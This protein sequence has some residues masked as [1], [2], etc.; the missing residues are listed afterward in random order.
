MLHNAP[1]DQMPVM[2]A[3]T[4]SQVGLLAESVLSG[5]PAL[6]LL[7]IIARFQGEAVDE[8]AM[9][10]AWQAMASRHPALRMSMDPLNPAGP[11][12]TFHPAIEVDF[13]VLDWSHVPESRHEARL[14]EWIEQD[15][16]QAVICDC[17]PCWR[18]RLI[19]CA[20]DQA[21]IVWTFHHALLDGSGYRIILR[22]M[23]DL[24]EGCCADRS[25]PNVA[26]D[27]PDFVTF[28]DAIAALDH[29]DAKIFFRDH[30]SGFDTPNRLDPIFA[31]HRDLN[32]QDDRQKRMHLVER[33]DAELSNAIRTRAAQAGSTTAN[34]ISAA[35]A[36]V[37]ARCS[38]RDEVVFGLT[39][40]GRYLVKDGD[41]IAG[42]QINTLPCRAQL[43]GQTVDA[44][45]HQLR[46]FT[47]A[48]HAFEH[49][50]SSA[51]SEV[52]DVQGG[53]NL[54]DSFV[55]FE[56]GSLPLQMQ[57]QQADRHIEEQSQMATMMS[58]SAY[59]DPEM[60]LRFDGDPSRI[61]D[62]GAKRIFGYLRTALR[63]LAF[64]PSDL[65][66]SCVDMLSASETQHLLALSKPEVPT[67]EDGKSIIAQFEEIARR[68]PDHIA[69]SQ[70]GTADK[71]SYAA[72][73][74]YANHLAHQLYDRGV[75]PGQ[76]VGLALPRGPDF[77]AALLAVL[78]IQAVFLPLDPSYP[79]AALQD[80]I[81]R[82]EV[83]ATFATQETA[84]HFLPRDM[85]V[86]LLGGD[87][88]ISG[89]NAPLARGPYDPMGRAYIIFTSGSTGK[90][91][92]VEVPHS[93]LSQHAQAM[94]HL[95]ALSPS[96]HVL[97]F[98]SLNF[99]V[100]IEEILP[101]LLAGGHLV[102]RNDDVAQSIPH[103][104]AA[105]QTHHITV[106]NLPTAFW[107]VLVAHLESSGDR[108]ASSLRLMIV[109]GER[110]SGE[111]LTSWQ[112]M[113][114]DIR[115]VN[116]YGPTEATIT[117]VCYEATDIC[118]KG[119]PVPIGRPTGHARAYVVAQDGSLAPEGVSGELWV[120]GAAVALGYLH[121][122]DLTSEVFLTDHFEAHCT[123]ARPARIY[124]T[125][126]RVAWLPEGNLAYHGRMDRQVKLRGYRIELSAIEAA[127]ETHA[128]VSNVV[129]L[130]DKAD[131]DQARL[132]AW[133]RLHDGATATDVSL[134]QDLTRHLPAYMVPHITIVEHFPE[135]P[136]GKI[137]TAALPRPVAATL[138]ESAPADAATLQVM[139]IFCVL[140][141]RKDV[142]P[143]QSFFDLGG[144]SLLSVRL[145]SLLERDFNRRLTL[146]TLYQAPTPRQIAAK[147]SLLQL[148]K[149]PDC[150]V[151]LQPF[152]SRPPLYAV[153]IL[154]DKGVFFQPL[155]DRLG[156]DQPLL[157][158]TMDLLDPSAPDSLSEIAAIYAANIQ[159]HNRDRP[160]Q[161]IAVSQGSYLAYELA[162]QLLARGCDVAA[163]YLLDAEGPGGRPRRRP[164]RSVGA[165]AHKLR[166][167]FRGVVAG[168]RQEFSNELKFRY[169]RL[170]LSLSRIPGISTFVRPSSTVAAHQAAI[171]LAIASYQPQ[172]YTRKI[173]LFVGRD[174]QFDTPE[175]I[176][177]GLGWDVVASGGLQVIE[178]AGDHLTMIREPDLG[179]LEQHL[180]PLLDNVAAQE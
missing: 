64:A 9:R 178:T 168:R 34:M 106:C 157:G 29:T 123:D 113:H 45:L 177:S 127:L 14:A 91:K 46:D 115:W 93:A 52:C 163:L 173:T 135:T 70:I 172:P 103:L 22:D 126:D 156:R 23:F 176:A 7:Q 6:N 71:L 179:E 82:S 63:Q 35:W 78:K 86:L 28:C 132:L 120:G 85:P 97:Q 155:A 134:S 33:L 149:F 59:D 50:P 57:S 69:V 77:I 112:A 49:T 171:D 87:R 99:D 2:V 104:L 39:R 94:T 117:S 17:A 150:L 18:V 11:R 83:V 10:A 80:M 105:L 138:V 140:L 116:G 170:R 121:R 118:F 107:H 37:M 38:G 125:G 137:D 8:P 142:G 90:P 102:M 143:D 152:G 48:I 154:G 15:R 124:R 169:N 74:S 81:T 5:K 1:Q 159:R 61:S 161:L 25:P 44:L 26:S 21:T 164:Q 13:A 165:Y 32:A 174:N 128:A 51:I 100:S 68:Q 95:F 24:Y 129:V 145:M 136:G 148:D 141:G 146:A 79:A 147:L 40:S 30:L 133:V 75:K 101:T 131:T 54:F 180:R 12:L 144:H 41:M 166:H 60:L 19:K 151:P 16:R 153:H 62:E 119:G 72:L 110:V 67:F 53:V 56:R 160:T 139:N 42:C 47:R 92:G 111:V 108:V 4:P 122:P 3:M 89:K 167:N 20:D 98:A 88:V 27:K 31:P 162:Q 175:G 58:L 43:S 73:D 96:D 66:L 84:A 114:P 55:L 109:G 36:L 130:L 158:L 65:P 76:V